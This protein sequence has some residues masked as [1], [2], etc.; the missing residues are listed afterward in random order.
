MQMTKQLSRHG[1]WFGFGGVR[2]IDWLMAHLPS[3]PIGTFPS[4]SSFWI[5]LT[6]NDLVL[7]SVQGG[8]EP[9]SSQ[10]RF[11]TLS[12]NKVDISARS[13]P[14]MVADLPAGSSSI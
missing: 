7:A 14:I 5:I 13:S 10:P 6:S 11:M 1:T 9:V 2:P 12:G 3:Q 4:A 8:L